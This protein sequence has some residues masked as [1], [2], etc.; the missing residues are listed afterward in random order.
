MGWGGSLDQKPLSLS[1]FLS[2]REMEKEGPN[3]CPLLIHVLSSHQPSHP[4]HFQWSPS[5]LSE[6]LLA[7][8]RPRTSRKGRDRFLL[9]TLSSPLLSFTHL[10]ARCSM[11]CT[12]GLL[13]RR[14]SLSVSSLYGGQPPPS[15]MLP[16]VPPLSY[17][18]IHSCVLLFNQFLRLK[19]RINDIL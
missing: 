16:A 2:K 17:T 12:I 3:N 13:S 1:L 15:R 4:P 14:L 6:V 8:I 10:C 7:E 18:P 5:F 9:L 19:M 11:V